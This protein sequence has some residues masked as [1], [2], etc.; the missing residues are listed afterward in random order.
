MST[1]K[2]KNDIDTQAAV[3]ALEYLLAEG[4]VSKRRLYKENFLRG[5]FFSVGSI[6]GATLVIAVLLWA[7]SLFNQVPFIGDITRNVQDTI[8]T[9]Q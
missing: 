3:Q 1:D 6:I 8:N 9:S 7:L 5:I 4:Y 2:K